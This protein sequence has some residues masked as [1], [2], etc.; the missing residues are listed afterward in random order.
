MLS[1]HKLKIVDGYNMSVDIFKKLVPNF[2]D[3]K[4]RA[5]L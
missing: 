5:S 4:V 3:K 2:F 1:V